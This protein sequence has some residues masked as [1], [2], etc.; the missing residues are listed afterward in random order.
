MSVESKIEIMSNSIKEHHNT[1]KKDVDYLSARLSDLA[2]VVRRNYRVP[3]ERA[4]MM[5][6]YVLP[7]RDLLNGF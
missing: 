6:L 1:G 2:H 3:E 7:V 5:N 4:H